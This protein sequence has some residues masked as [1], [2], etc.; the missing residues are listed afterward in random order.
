MEYREQGIAAGGNEWKSD[1]LAI[2]SLVA[3]GAISGL[4]AGYVSHLML[5]AGTP[6]GL[7]LL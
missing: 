2:L 3:A 4:A 5:D 1:L 7:P 6:K